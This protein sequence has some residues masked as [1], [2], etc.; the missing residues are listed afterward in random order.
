MKLIL[1]SSSPRRRQLLA[2][3]GYDFVVIEPADDEEAPDGLAPGDHAT[4][5]ARRKAKAVAD[6]LNSG[7][8]LG[9][10][11]VVEAGNEIIGKPSDA[12][13]AT[14]ILTRLSGTRHA[15]TTALCLI[16]AATGRDRC[17]LD[18]T[19]IQMRN[20]SR[21]AIEA[22]VATGE[23]FG[24]AGAY[25]IQ[26]NGDAFIE[27]IEGSFSNVVGLPMELLAHMLSADEP[28]FLCDANVGKLARWLRILGFD[29]VFM[30]PE[31]DEELILRGRKDGRI[32]LTTDRGIAS[33]PYLQEC[34]LIESRDYRLQLKQV[35][36]TF[37][38]APDRAKVFSRCVVCNSPVRRALKPDVQSRVPPRALASHDDFFECPGCGRV[39]WPGS[40]VRNTLETLRLMGL[41]GEGTNREA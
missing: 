9:A 14:Q 21:D 13:H 6:G 25:A 20:V 4:L 40:H 3:A 1:A 8:V 37:G 17:E 31:R 38:L 12:Q 27:R 22:Y 26:E 36:E 7:L 5:L 18:T 39:Y 30:A 10:D 23:C 16:D 15:V 35:C 33:R 28:K 32:I 2:D 29:T 11:T 19:V 41:V 24:K 34:L